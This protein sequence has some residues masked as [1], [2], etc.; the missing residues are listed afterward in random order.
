MSHKHGRDAHTQS[1]CDLLLGRP[2]KRARKLRIHLSLSL[3]MWHERPQELIPVLAQ[4]RSPRWRPFLSTAPLAQGPQ[5]GD[6]IWEGHR[7]GFSFTG[8]I[9]W[10]GSRSLQRPQTSLTSMSTPCTK[11]VLCPGELY[12][13]QA[14]LSRR[15]SPT[16][17]GQPALLQGHISIMP[18][19]LEL[20]HA[21][22]DAHPRST[23]FWW[24]LHLESTKG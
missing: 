16:A 8:D 21:P 24:H 5:L 23:L 17:T 20:Q 14:A 13:P 11:L 12:T 22:C 1:G 6:V 2:G 4:H 7:S 19:R 9:S 15:C 18:V 10:E 3:S